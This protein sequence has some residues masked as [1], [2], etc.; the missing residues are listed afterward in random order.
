MGG[1]GVSTATRSGRRSTFEAKR[2]RTGGPA[3]ATAALRDAAA[4]QHRCPRPSV[5]R[6][7]PSGRNCGRA[8]A[9]GS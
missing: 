7:A 8:T 4:N 6:V 2:R 3:A 1:E 9:R 5:S